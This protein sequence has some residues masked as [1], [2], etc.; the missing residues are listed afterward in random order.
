MQL[1]PTTPVTPNLLPP[2]QPSLASPLL[3]V[4]N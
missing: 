2:E 4:A 3:H 1:I